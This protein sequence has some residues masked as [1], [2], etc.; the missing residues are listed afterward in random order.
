MT[1]TINAFFGWDFNSC[2]A[3]RKDGVWYPIDFANPC[4]D[5]QVTS[6][7][8]HFPWLVKANLRWSIFCA[9]TKRPMRENLDWEPFFEIA[10]D[11]LP[12]PREARGLRGDRR[13]ALRGRAL[14][15]VLREA[16]RRTSTRSRGS[17]SA[18]D[19]AKDAVRQKVAALFP[20]HEVEQFTELF[21]KRIQDWRDAKRPTTRQA[22]TR[23]RE[24]MPAVTA[25]KPP[26]AGDRAAAGSGRAKAVG[27][28][29][30]RQRGPP[31][32]ATPRPQPARDRAQETDAKISAKWHSERLRRKCS[33]C[34][35]ATS[36]A[37]AALPDR[38]RRRRGDRALPDDRRARAAARGRRDQDLLVRQRRRRARWSQ[39]RA[40]RAPDVAAEPVPPVRATR[41]RAGDPQRLQDRRTSRSGRPARRSARSTRVAVVCRFPDV[42]RT[43]ARDERHLRPASASSTPRTTTDDFCVSSPL[44]FVP[45]LRGPHLD[46]LRT[47]YHPPRVRAR[48]VRGHRR[49][50]GGWRDVLGEK[51]IPN[52]VD[53]WGAEWH[54]DWLTWRAMLPQYLGRVR[55]RREA[56]DHDG[57]ARR[58]TDEDRRST[59]ER[60]RAPRRSCA[61]CCATCA[62]SSACSTRACSRAACA[63][64]APSRRCSS[65]TAPAAR[66]RRA[67]RC[68]SA[69]DDPHFTTELGLFK[70][71]VNA[72]S[73]ALRRRRPRADG[74]AARR[75][76]STS[77]ARRPPARATAVVSRASCRRSARPTSASTTWCRARATWRSTSVMTAAARRRLRLLDQGPR[78]ARRCGTTR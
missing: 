59:V 73:A 56:D 25:S 41:G 24:R 75:R 37:G 35:G 57:R 66:R 11:G 42:F 44:H 13:R 63:A 23:R 29:G 72:R 67:A 20:A 14:R 50:A 40:R 16:P 34:A 53:S 18:R 70:L 3:L 60:R 46:V 52:R 43:R 74:G 45:H 62:R 27:A 21:W 47:R 76:S 58:K 9:A 10:A 6:L 78:R 4:P 7:H 5:S 65:S 26:S 55:A 15:G 33:S 71:E 69:L 48:G 49:V 36:A 54:H 77:C 64:S 12:V 19:R 22:R 31:A 39:A 51:G 68:S 2:E 38:R 61:T 32:Q 8:Y 30:G 1:L 28:A 17:S